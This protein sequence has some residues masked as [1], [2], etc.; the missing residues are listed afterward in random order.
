MKMLGSKILET[1]RLILKPQTMEEQK[2]LWE[3]LMLPEVNRLYLSI[4]RKFKDKLFDWEKQEPFYKKD[5]ERAN[6]PDVFRWSL[7][8]KETGECIGRYSCQDGPFEDKPEIRDVGWYIDPKYNGKGYGTEA[9][10]V[11]IDYM[12]TECEIDEI[13]TSAAIVNPASWKIME[14]LGFKRLP[15]T[16]WVDYTFMEE[17]VEDY[18][19]HLTKEMYFNQNK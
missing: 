19:Y 11:M 2:Y 9:A 8:L 18:Q 14:K 3:V 7:F 17:P 1:D 5:M 10:K 15:E 12:F 4:S 16:K 6:D 13:I